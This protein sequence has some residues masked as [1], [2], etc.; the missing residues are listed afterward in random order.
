MSVLNRIFASGGREV[1][2]PTLEI[3]CAAWDEPILLCNGFEDHVCITE[4]ARELTF[5]AAPIEVALPKRNTSGTQTLTF[6]IGNVS[7]IAREKI[8]QALDTGEMIRLTLREFLDTDKSA[9]AGAPLKF[10]VRDVTMERATV[11]VTA[12]FFD[13]I[14]TAWPRMFYTPDFAPG[15]KYIS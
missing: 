7:G 5:T 15:L 11:Q 1:V 9:P 12:A 6:A 3:A 13:L 10:V 4:D 8:E 2:I 14:N